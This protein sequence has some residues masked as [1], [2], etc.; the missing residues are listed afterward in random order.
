[1]TTFILRIFLALSL[2]VSPFA[3]SAIADAMIVNPAL[4]GHTNC[5]QNMALNDMTCVDNGCLDSN[6]SHSASTFNTPILKNSPLLLNT[7]GSKNIIDRYRPN[8]VSQISISIYRP[9]IT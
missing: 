6:C 4:D 5:S 3:Q 2:I 8:F 1:M 7:N 9:P